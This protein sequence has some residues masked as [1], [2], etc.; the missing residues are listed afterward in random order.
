[1]SIYTSGSA[2]SRNRLKADCE[3]CFGL[4]CTALPFSSS[5]DFA[6]DKPAGQPCSNLN[7]HFKCGIH[8]RLR[9]SGFKGCTVYDCFGA[10]QQVSQITFKGVDWREDALKASLMFHVFPMMWQ[11]H[12]LLWY[13]TQAR[14]MCSSSTDGL[15]LEQ[16][17]D[18]TEQLTL[19]GPEE[20]AQ[21]NL[22]E[23]RAEVNTLLVKYSEQIRAEAASRFKISSRHNIKRG[24]DLIGAKLNNADLR[25]ANLRGVYFI[26]SDLRG[27]DLRFA[28]VIG[29]D[30]RDAD[31]SGADLSDVLFLTQMQVNAAIG[32]KLTKLPPYFDTPDHWLT[33]T[34]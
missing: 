29:A 14:E 23:H 2:A 34:S 19:L 9:Q 26:A 4:C 18:K 11:L 1:M 10:G 21:I 16:M 20:L 31:I 22:P 5:S 15:E 7:D 28:D 32:D 17:L 8:S 3:Q 12:E 13:V 6:M 33:S 25:C 30:F 24:A 27:A